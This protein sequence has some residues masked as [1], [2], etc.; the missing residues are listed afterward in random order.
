MSRINEK[1]GLKPA[2]KRSM[3]KLP[4]SRAEA[5][6]LTAIQCPSCARRG[7]RAMTVRGVRQYLCQWCSHLW[8]AR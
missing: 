6:V 2:G 8:E 3:M 4:A 7:V 1:L 5:A